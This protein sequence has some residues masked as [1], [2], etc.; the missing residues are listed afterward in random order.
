S[1]LA[2]GWQ[3]V[4]IEEIAVPGTSPEISPSPL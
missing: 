2:R 3:E 4:P 1:L